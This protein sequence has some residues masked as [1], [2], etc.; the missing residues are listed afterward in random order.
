MPAS[1]VLYQMWD[2]TS[3]E[4]LQTRFMSGVGCV[5]LDGPVSDYRFQKM[6]C[7]DTQDVIP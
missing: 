4:Y 7:R 2:S 3:G 1:S 5:A 6:C